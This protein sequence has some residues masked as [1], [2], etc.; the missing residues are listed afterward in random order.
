[1][2]STY[3]EHTSLE[4]MKHILLG[5]LVTYGLLFVVGVVLVW[6]V[7]KKLGKRK[8]FG[9]PVSPIVPIFPTS[10]TQF[11]PNQTGVMQFN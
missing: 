8:R 9:Q 4:G 1:M 3:V 7:L 10:P 5:L 6:H 11:Q 2:L